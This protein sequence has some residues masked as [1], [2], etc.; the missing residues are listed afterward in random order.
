MVTALPQPPTTP[1]PVIGEGMSTVADR[2]GLMNGNFSDG[3]IFT[4]E[5]KR[6]KSL[7]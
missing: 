7:I 5:S 2:L 1:A 4:H 3:G 6:A